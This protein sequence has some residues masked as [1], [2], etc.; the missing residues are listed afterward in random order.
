[1]HATRARSPCRNVFGFVYTI[2]LFVGEAYMPPGRGVPRAGFPG[3]PSVSP[4]LPCKTNAKQTVDRQRRTVCPVFSNSVAQRAT[5]SF[6]IFI[7]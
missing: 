3:K 5:H 4:A 1:M 7:F 2:P 6:F